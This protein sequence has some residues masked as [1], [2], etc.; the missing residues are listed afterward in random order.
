VSEHIQI[1]NFTSIGLSE[2]WLGNFSNRNII[3]ILYAN[4]VI[5][6]QNYKNALR[7][8]REF[9]TDR[10]LVWVVQTYNIHA[11]SNDVTRHNGHAIPLSH[12]ISR[13]PK[14][15]VFAS[16]FLNRITQLILKIVV[17]ENGE[18]I[19]LAQN[20][21]Y[22]SKLN[23]SDVPINQTGFMSYFIRFHG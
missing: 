4:I 8:T 5:Y 20:I 6:I 9:P 12:S 18:F 21:Y 23:W 16:S 17:I 15:Y 3:S 10:L 2:W 1:Y 13:V 14:S 7:F 11:I 22:V 19:D